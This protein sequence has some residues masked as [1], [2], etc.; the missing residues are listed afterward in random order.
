MDRSPDETGVC[1]K[2]KRARLCRYPVQ[3]PKDRKPVK[4]GGMES[5]VVRSVGLVS[6]TQEAD[7]IPTESYG[8][9]RVD[10]NPEYEVQEVR[11]RSEQ[12]PKRKRG[13]GEEGEGE[14]RREKENRGSKDRMDK[15]KYRKYKTTQVR[16]N[17]QT[18]EHARA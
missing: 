5:D 9:S 16:R 3:S 6:E 10:L 4:S 2:R 11:V 18:A 15:A 12:S 13:V 17:T 14:V 7:L 1:D 8:R